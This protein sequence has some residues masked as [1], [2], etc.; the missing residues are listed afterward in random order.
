M[1]QLTKFNQVY[2]APVAVLPPP[3]PN[4]NLKSF[5]SDKEVTCKNCQAGK[6]FWSWNFRTNRP[7]LIDKYSSVHDCPTP[8]TTDVFPGWCDKCSA[9]DL[10]WLRK[11]EGF[12]LSENY[13]L[14]HACEQSGSPIH[15]MSVAKCKHCSATDLFWV[16]SH[17]RW[18]LTQSNG[19]K[20][21]C[22]NYPVYMK[23]WA[24]ALR[25][26]YALQKAWLKSIPDNT[27][28]KKCKGKTYTSFLSKNKKTMLMCNSSEPILM[29]R[30]CLRCKRLGTF[31]VEKKKHYLKELRKKYWPWRQGLHKWKKADHGQ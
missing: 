18:T 5:R 8:N 14:P 29:H 7:H 16:R 23:D 31:S 19:I 17:T 6:L 22:P 13:G 15:D 12:E 28:C 24:E 27:E 30:P 21:D 1:I 4:W 11:K 20:H 2:T 9:P 10:L 3:I 26:D 25:M